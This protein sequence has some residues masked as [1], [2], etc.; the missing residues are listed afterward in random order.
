M[1]LV[2]KD[3]PDTV[4]SG[5]PFIFEND[6]TS[7]QWITG[8]HL[9]WWIRI[10]SLKMSS[11]HENAFQVWKSH[12]V[13]SLRFQEF[14]RF[15]TKK[16]ISRQYI[17]FDKACVIKHVLYFYAELTKLKFSSFYKKIKKNQF[18]SESKFSIKAYN[19]ET[20][21]TV[22]NRDSWS[23][24]RD[25]VLLSI[26]NFTYGLYSSADTVK[27]VQKVPRDPTLNNFLRTLRLENC[28]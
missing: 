1:W 22:S 4:L 13:E 21:W 11:F 28:A 15:F 12:H 8:V 5:T 24:H 23:D 19:D 3:Q 25:A 20:V 6:C 9:R 18:R 14:F 2:C 26:T 17:N 16:N 27:A 7:S 10:S